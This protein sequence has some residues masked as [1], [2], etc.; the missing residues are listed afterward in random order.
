MYFVPILYLRS[1]SII[2]NVPSVFLKRFA[3]NAADY[4]CKDSYDLCVT[5]YISFIVPSFGYEMSRSHYIFQGKCEFLGF[6]Y[7]KDMMIK[8]FDKEFYIVDL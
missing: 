2:L 6:F 5:S 4:L 1:Y 8:Y 7:T 3:K